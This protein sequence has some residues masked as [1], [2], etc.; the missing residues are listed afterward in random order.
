MTQIGLSTKKRSK[1]SPMIILIALPR[2]LLNP[3]EA[4]NNGFALLRE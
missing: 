3:K 1:R 2:V 4:K